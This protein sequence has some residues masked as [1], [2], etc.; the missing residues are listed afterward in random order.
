[1]SVK[2][3]PSRPGWYTV[4]VYDRVSAPGE[5]PAKVSRRVQGQRNAENAER[6]LLNQRDAGSLTA[7]RQ[8]LAAYADRYLASRRAEV[9]RP[10][11]ASYRKNVE[12]YIDRHPISKMRVG[13]IDVTAVSGFYADLLEGVGR[14]VK[15]EDGKLVP[16]APVGVETVRGVHRVLSMMLKRATVDG[17][18][19]GNPCTIA[20]VPKKNAVES[21]EESEPGIDPEAAQR[22]LAAIEGTVVYT[23]GATALGTGLRVSELLGLKWE[24]VDLEAGEMHLVGK[25]EQVDGIVERTTLKTKRSR[26]TVPFGARVVAI[27]KQQKRVIAE[28]RLRLAKDGL[29]VDEG[30]CFPVL[31]VS[32]TRAGAVLPA[33]RWWPPD[34]YEKAWRR[35]VRRA[36]GIALGEYVL[37]GGAVEDFEP[38]WT[39]GIHAHRHAYATVQ[40]AAGVRDEVVSRR[41]GH[42]S[43][44]VTRGVYS[45]VTHA[46]EREGVDVADGLL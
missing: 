26:R 46:E 10:T 15:D 27:L 8:T 25:L 2:E 6:Q 32:S 9:S 44:L 33:G 38:P 28:T 36:N 18:L 23:I 4:V 21:L 1:M 37:A 3:I 43:S 40:L 31:R 35:A 19:P 16:A 34:A 17:L 20:K 22:F 14:D 12:R 11:L 29:W 13:D 30:W 41:L 42:S 39:H 7:R 5:K 24:D 45:H